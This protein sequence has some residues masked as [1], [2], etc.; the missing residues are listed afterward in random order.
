MARNDLFVVGR[1][2]AAFSS[3]LAKAAVVA[4]IAFD[5]SAPTYIFL[6]EIRNFYKQTHQLND[7][8][9]IPSDTH[10]FCYTFHF[11]FPSAFA[12]CLSWGSSSIT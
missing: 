2:Q 1:R 7:D 12:R 5:S 6:I 8:P 3:V 9:G 11:N 4:D 10:G